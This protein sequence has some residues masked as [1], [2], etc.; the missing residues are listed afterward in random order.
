MV[1]ALREIWNLLG[2][3]AVW[4]S[5]LTVI[6]IATGIVLKRFIDHS[7]ESQLEKL[8]ESQTQDAF[9]RDLY[10]ENLKK[11]SSEQAQGLR[12]AYLLLFESHSST[13]IDEKKS[14]DEQLEM[15]IQMIMKPLRDY[16]GGLDESTIKKINSVG[17]YL[18][19][20]HPSCEGCGHPR[21]L[22]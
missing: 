3:P 18:R 2:I 10:A 9:I 19:G 21:N 12:Q 22:A 14:H 4:G 17:N 11:Y 16:A 15:A 6:I 20:V 5:I 13:V 7:F 8:K 1:D